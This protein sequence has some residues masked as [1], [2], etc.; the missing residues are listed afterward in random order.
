MYVYCIEIVNLIMGEI[1]YVRHIILYIP[2]TASMLLTCRKDFFLDV[3][4]QF[5]V[6]SCQTWS[7]FGEV[8]TTAIRVIVLTSS[9]IGILLAIIALVVSFIRHKAM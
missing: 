6:A 7:Q 3:E 8:N 1:L 9:F 4:L 5:C 2:V